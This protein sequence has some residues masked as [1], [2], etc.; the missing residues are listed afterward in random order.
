MWRNGQTRCSGAHAYPIQTMLVLRFP[1]PP[2][3]RTRSFPPLTRDVGSDSLQGGKGSVRNRKPGRVWTGSLR[4]RAARRDLT[5]APGA[6]GEA[7]GGKTEPSRA[8]HPGPGPHPATTSRPRPGT[9]SARGGPGGGVALPGSPE[10]DSC[11]RSGGPL[12]S[13]WARPRPVVASSGQGSASPTPFLGRPGRRDR[14]Q[15]AG[16]CP[17]GFGRGRDPAIHTPPF[18]HARQQFGCCGLQSLP[19]PLHAPPASPLDAGAQPPPREPR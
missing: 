2:E 4:G 7:R 12:S 9:G 15:G 14:S 18:R 3:K 13:R 6:C 1:S 8:V 17:T 11:P 16:V 19:H 5:L 10:P